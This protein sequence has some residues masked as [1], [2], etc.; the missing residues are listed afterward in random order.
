VCFEKNGY[1]NGIKTFILPERRSIRMLGIYTT[2]LHSNRIHTESLQ[3]TEASS[4]IA[5]LYCPV[6]MKFILIHFPLCLN[7]SPNTTIINKYE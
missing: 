6:S 1:T 7:L 4:L 2:D 5:L 3:P